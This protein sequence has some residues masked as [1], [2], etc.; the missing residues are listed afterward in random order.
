MNDKRQRRES[1][2]TAAEQQQ[3]VELLQDF[4]FPSACHKIQSTSTG[5]CLIA[6]GNYP[7]QVRLFDVANL[8]PKVTRH[9]DADIVDFEACPAQETAFPLSVFLVTDSD[10]GFFKARFS[11]CRSDSEAPCAIWI[12]LRNQDSDLWPCGYLCALPRP[13]ADRRIVC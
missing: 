8:S 2:Q 13:S 12:L 4:R 5:D 3:R 9:F 1:S 10:G 6:T 7:P 11:L